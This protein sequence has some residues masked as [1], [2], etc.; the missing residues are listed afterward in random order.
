MRRDITG[1]LAGDLVALL[2]RA[3]GKGPKGGASPRKEGGREGVSPELVRV[4]K[5][6]VGTLVEG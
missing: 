2:D 6:F 1:E 4:V 3:G 5:A